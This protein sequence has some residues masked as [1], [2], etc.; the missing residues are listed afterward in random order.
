MLDDI[1]GA[2]GLRGVRGA[3][4][5]R[6]GPGRTDENV[7]RLVHDFPA[8]HEMDLNR[9]LPVARGTAVDVR[10]VWILLRHR[11]VPA[12]AGEILRPCDVSCSPTPWA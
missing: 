2:A 1:A 8:I 12:G 4:G 5:D 9:Y 3:P 6:E 11:S 10:I 7:S